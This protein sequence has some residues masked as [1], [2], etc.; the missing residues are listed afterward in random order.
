MLRP[1]PMTRALIVGPRDK[2]ET[3]VES[4]YN[5]KLVHIVDHREG[6]EGLEI[7]RPLPTASEASEILV[8]LRSIASVLQLVETKPIPTE[9]VA[10]DLREKILSLELNISEEDAA[11]KKTQALL[12]DLNRKIDEV[13]P[14]AQLPLSLADYRGYDTLEVFVGKIAGE[15]E[16]LD[17]VT[18]DY[19]AFSAPGLLAVFVPKPQAAAVR[20]FLTQRGFTSIP[21][22]EGEGDPREIL[23]DLLAERERWEARLKEVEQRLDTLRER[24]AG[25]L[26][27]AKARLEMTVEKA[28]A[29]LR[30]AVTDHTFIVEGWVPTES[31]EKLESG[32]GR[33]P[34]LFVT[35]LEQDHAPEHSEESTTVDPPVMLRNPKP[36]RP[37]E[38]L[39][40]LFSTPDYHEIDPTFILI[41]TFPIFFGLMVGDA[42]YGLVWMA[43]GL[44]LIRRWKNRPWDFW[45]NLLVTLIWGGFW[46]VLFGVFFFGEAFGI[47]FHHPA[48]AST[49]VALL[50]WSGILG[51]N[52]PLHAP[53]EKLEQI[54][55]FIVLSIVAAYVHLAIGFVVGLVNDMGHS[56]KHALGKVAWLLILT[57]FFVVMIVRSA[58]W[59]LDAEGRTPF[60]YLVWN[61]PL[62]WFPRA[63]YVY[64]QV[65][66]G[67]NNPIPWAAIALLVG[68][69][70]LLL[71]TE[72]PLHIMEFFGLLANIVSYARLAAVGIAKAAMAFA[73]NV[74]VLQTMIFPALDSGNVVFL[75]L[76]FLVGIIIALLF[77][78]I[79]F[80]LGAVTAIIQ[81]IRLNY[82]E[83]F[84]K[85][86]RGTGTPFR[87]FGERAKP[88]V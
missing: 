39:V 30:F 74:I 44:W 81:A 17:S 45:K 27:A 23:S 67:P 9:E 58:R 19:K 56:R 1:V 29:P 38:M 60:G 33:F 87:P 11:K 2:L 73:F 52:I 55:D 8:K 48:L 61:K 43:Y 41:F 71:A 28:E 83:F 35:E 42:G 69:V 4:L 85:F 25:F 24:Y 82:V 32:L 18:R 12:Q 40:N 57:G 88:E 54:T 65:G 70:G 26:S 63:G 22:P 66:F 10:G 79:V 20:D 68:G 49:R 53:L 34:G 72:G 84:I 80:L 15:I 76:G 3:T 50:D 6:E 78:L 16:G 62:G 64:T 13:R 5:L 21:V 47:P 75:I 51:V 46:S 31:F 37:F 14:F 7:G 77:H 86:F 36:L 59:P